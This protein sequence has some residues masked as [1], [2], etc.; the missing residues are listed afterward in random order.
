MN[1]YD[2]SKMENY[3]ISDTYAEISNIRYDEKKKNKKYTRDST[4][5]LKNF[6]I[7]TPKP[8]RRK[9]NELRIKQDV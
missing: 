8:S 9:Q 3:E 7:S 4:N 5:S 2:E 1:W 6:N